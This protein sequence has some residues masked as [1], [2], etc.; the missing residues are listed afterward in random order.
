MA[1]EN[2]EKKEEEKPEIYA[3]KKDGKKM[4]Y[5]RRDFLVTAAAGASAIGL[6]GAGINAVKSADATKRTEQDSPD[7]VKLEITALSFL[8]VVLGQKIERTWRIKNTG[9]VDCPPAILH[10]ALKEDPKVQQAVQVSELAAGKSVEVPVTLEL[11]QVSGKYT[12]Q[13]QLKLGEGAARLN[14]IH[15]ALS[16]TPLAESPHNY[17]DDYDNTWTIDNPDSASVSS[18]I[19]FSRLEVEDNFDYVYVEDGAGNVV[20]TI[21]GSYPN[22]LWSDQVNDHV[23]KVR[24]TSDYSINYWGFLVDEISSS[25]YF[26]YLPLVTRSVPTPTSYV[27]CSCNTIELCT[28]NLVCVCEAVC[29]CDGYCSCDTVCTCES[30]CSCDGYCTCNQVCTCDTIHYWYPN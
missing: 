14:E 27:V 23:V 26:V 21:T 20:Q 5:N 13:W 2:Q 8:A 1:D 10:L 24:L 18:Y 22:G 30:V 4:S 3:V 19:H 6:I 28:C 9:K 12:Y 11:P 16:G 17:P 29:S 15:L 25:F 7:A